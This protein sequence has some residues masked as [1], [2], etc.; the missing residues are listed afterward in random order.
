MDIKK[1]DLI[2]VQ[3]VGETVLTGIDKEAFKGLSLKD[4]KEIAAA[5]N[6]IVD[7]VAAQVEKI[8]A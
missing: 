6:K 4:Y 5:M 1:K 2:F 3:K 7:F 8:E